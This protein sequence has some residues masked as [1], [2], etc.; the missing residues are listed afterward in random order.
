PLQWVRITV[1]CPECEP[2]P[3]APARYCDC[4]GHQLPDHLQH[5]EGPTVAGP[6]D[7]QNS[8]FDWAPSPNRTSDLRCPSCAGPRFDGNRCQACREQDARRGESMTPAPAT[9]DAAGAISANAEAHHAPHTP[10]SPPNVEKPVAARAKTVEP[11]GR[12]P[13]SPRRSTAADAV[14]AEKMAKP[15]SVAPK[16]PTVIAPVEAEAPAPKPKQQPT[17]LV[18]I[19]VVIA[20]LAAGGYWYRVYAKP[21]PPR[22]QQPAAVVPAEN[23]ESAADAAAGPAEHS[24]TPAA[25]QDR[26]NA[27]PKERP[28]APVTTPPPPPQAPTSAPPKARRSASTPDS[29]NQK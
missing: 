17:A 3:P 1:R 19:G 15:S 27:V 16:R 2:K 22:V 25:V 14:Y 24:E 21:T 4:C 29:A 13:E 7:Q 12:T 6:A 18:A 20:A 23:P 8:D 9:D 10:Q 11:E 26:N 28:T 5:Q